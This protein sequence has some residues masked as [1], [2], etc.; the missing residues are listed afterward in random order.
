MF[1]R[2][3]VFICLIELKS[4]IWNQ[5][6]RMNAAGH[7]AHKAF[8][9]FWRV[10]IFTLVCSDANVH[11]T[12]FKCKSGLKWC[13][14]ILVLS[15]CK[16]RSS[17]G[18]VLYIVSWKPPAPPPQHHRIKLCVRYIHHN[19]LQTAFKEEFGWCETRL[20][21][22]SRSI[23]LTVFNI[24]MNKSLRWCWFTRSLNAVCPLPDLH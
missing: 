13:K 15:E 4:Q 10:N 24:Q 17:W 23:C 16:C 21:V 2:F 7:E 9:I 8:F 14:V 12:H 20:R 11:T 1:N 6:S 5:F 19:I 22:C 18:A 3:S